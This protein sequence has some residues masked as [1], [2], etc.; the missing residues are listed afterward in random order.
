MIVTSSLIVGESSTAKRMPVV[1]FVCATSSAT[2]MPALI[3]ENRK[4]AAWP[5]AGSARNAASVR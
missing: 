5:R 1:R 2:S 3:N 4:T